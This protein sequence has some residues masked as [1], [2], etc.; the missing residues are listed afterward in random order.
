MNEKEN[1]EYLV[2]NLA[3]VFCGR[4]EGPTPVF[5]WTGRGKQ[6]TSQDNLDWNRLP[7]GC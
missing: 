1:L 2:G 6:T 7:A 4:F 3:G 5:H